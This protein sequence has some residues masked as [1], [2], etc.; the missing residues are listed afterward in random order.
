MGVRVRARMCVRL[1]VR[2]HVCTRDD[3]HVYACGVHVGAGS[4]TCGCIRASVSVYALLLYYYICERS[5]CMR[6]CPYMCVRTCLRT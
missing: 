5:M 6:V 2:A 3:A 4:R 1:R